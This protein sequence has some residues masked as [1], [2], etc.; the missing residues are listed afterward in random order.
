MGFQLGKNNQFIL[1]NVC[2]LQFQIGERLAD[3][4]TPL[5]PFRDLLNAQKSTISQLNTFRPSTAARIDHSL[6]TLAYLVERLV[7]NRIKKTAPQ[8]SRPNSR[9]RHKRVTRS[10]MQKTLSS[11]S[12][13]YIEKPFPKNETHFNYM[14]LHSNRRSEDDK[15]FC[16][17][18]HFPRLCLVLEFGRPI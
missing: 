14:V 1:S 5:S 12:Q 15:V 8:I 2:L 3:T 4:T 17:F 13:I 7:T 11:T 10:N 6:T 9:T 18:E 16:I